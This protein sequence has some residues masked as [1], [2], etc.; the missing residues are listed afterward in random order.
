MD[1]ARGTPGT[2]LGPVRPAAPEPVL[3]RPPDPVPPAT[4]P[5]VLAYGRALPS[6]RPPE[7]DRLVR[8]RLTDALQELLGQVLDGSLELTVVPGAGRAAVLEHH[9]I[10]AVLVIDPGAGN[11]Y[12]LSPRELEI[13]RL[14]A[15]GATNQAIADALGISLWTVST[16]LRRVFAK[17]G[18]GSRA[19][20]VTA[21]F[22][23]LQL[24]L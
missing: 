10:R 19:E 6:P 4:R 22:G 1:R 9:G 8:Q 21:L 16:H 5:P 18:V 3:D 15:A 7:L 2:V 11:G 13:A 12:G 24:P 17:T 20:M 14:V 23:G